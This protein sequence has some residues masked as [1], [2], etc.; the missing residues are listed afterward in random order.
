[1]PPHGDDGAKPAT[2]R[3]RR[4]RAKRKVGMESYRL[5]LPVKKIT[6]AIMV[7]NKLSK[8]AIVT[9]AQTERALGDAITWWAERWIRIGH[10]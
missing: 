1:M 9:R 2:L 7:R 6:A 4:S 10:L 3:K 5:Y 8:D